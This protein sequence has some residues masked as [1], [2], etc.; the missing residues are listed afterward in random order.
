M[1]VAKDRCVFSHNKQIRGI[2]LVPQ[3][4]SG[5]DSNEKVALHGTEI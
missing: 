1:V 3:A 2:E 5:R 4:L